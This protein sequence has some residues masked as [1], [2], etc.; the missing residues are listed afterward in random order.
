MCGVW[1][2]RG[3]QKALS[4]PDGEGLQL[5]STLECLTTRGYSS[6]AGLNQKVALSVNYKPVCRDS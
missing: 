2:H 1:L 5:C 3:Q 6:M 4:E